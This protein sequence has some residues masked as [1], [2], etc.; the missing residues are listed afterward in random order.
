MQKRGKEDKEKLV[1]EKEE[2]KRLEKKQRETR[3][4]KDIER[5]LREIQ[6]MEEEEERHSPSLEEESVTPYLSVCGRLKLHILNCVK[7]YYGRKMNDNH[8]R[9]QTLQRNSIKTGPRYA[10]LFWLL[11]ERRR[12]MFLIKWTELTKEEIMERE[13]QR[14]G[15]CEIRRIKIYQIKTDTSEGP[16]DIGIVVEGMKVLTTLGNLPRACA[17]L[18]GLAYAVNLAYPKKLRVS[19]KLRSTL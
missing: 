1:M 10:E 16:N 2:G 9:E 4:K 3:I 15:Q 11:E 17:M 14:I 5:V 8:K 18:I 7:Y 12:L 6:F 13:W 19:I